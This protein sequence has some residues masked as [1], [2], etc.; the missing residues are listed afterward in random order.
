[1]TLPD[2]VHEL[3]EYEIACAYVAGYADGR[4]DADAELVAALAEALSSGQTTD[5]GSALRMHE[6]MAEQ[7]KRR[8]EWDA[9][10]AEPRADDYHGERAA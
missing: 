3:V 5:Y 2:A 1:M 6:R 9:N 7:A 8:R 10:A 4:A